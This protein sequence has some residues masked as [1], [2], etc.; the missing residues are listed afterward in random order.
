MMHHGTLSCPYLSLISS[1]HEACP[2]SFDLWWTGRNPMQSWHLLFSLLTASTQRSHFQSPSVV[3]KLSYCDFGTKLLPWLLLATLGTQARHFF[4]PKAALQRHHQATWFSIV[5]TKGKTLEVQL[6]LASA[7][8]CM[9]QRP[10]FVC[11]SRLLNFD[12]SYAFK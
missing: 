11:I 5:R 2:S 4:Q 3:H 12:S 10:P 7:H 6:P 8:C 9:R 1:F